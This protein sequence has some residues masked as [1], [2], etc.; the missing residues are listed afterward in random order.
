MATEPKKP[1]ARKTA[2]KQPKAQQEAKTE[3][4]SASETGTSAGATSESTVG[5]AASRVGEAVRELTNPVDRNIWIR[6]LIMLLF[7]FFIYVAQA[8]LGVAAIIQFVWMLLSKEPNSAIA[9]FGN[10]LGKWLERATRFQ[11]GA[12]EKLPFPWSDWE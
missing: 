4:M 8:L 3:K 1:A 2:A 9:G 12:T 7:F 10:S 6:G 5:A 11:T